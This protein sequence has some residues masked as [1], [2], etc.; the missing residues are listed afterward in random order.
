MPWGRVDDKHWHH[1]K[2]LELEDDLRKGCIAL[3]WLAIS[4]CNDRL[5]DGRVPAGTV[6][7]LG[8]DR[9]EADEL[10]RVGLW[11]VD[12][13]G[14]RVHDFL[15]F[16]KSKVQVETER[17]QRIEAGRL[18]AAARWNGG[19]PSGSP[20]GPPNGPPSTSPS[21][22][23]G[24]LDGGSD[25]PV[26]RNPSPESVR[27]IRP[28][29]VAPLRA[30]MEETNDPEGAAIT[31]LARHGCYL[32]PHSGYYRAVVLAVEQHG[33]NAYVGMLDRLAKAGMKNG[34]SK[35]YVFGAKDALDSQ[36]RPSLKALETEDRTEERAETWSRR[37]AATKARAHEN[38]LHVDPNPGC[39]L[40]AE[41]AKASA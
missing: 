33:V 8:G 40:C 28:R 13:R 17:A 7:T 10:V 2:I 6:R 1:E 31:W 37:T 27:S 38:G 9:E 12:G 16:N 34:D 39:P 19:P 26:S 5:T 24:E 23:T 30:P 22:P 11:E 15:D 29:A 14:Y 4:W 36:T 20:N 25:A 3:Y 18:G 21:E 41:E 32:Q 35:G